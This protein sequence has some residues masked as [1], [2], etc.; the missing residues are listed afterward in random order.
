M[1]KTSETIVFFGSGP[2]AAK[3]L[4]L[5]NS[6][7]E[8]E[9][10]VTKPQPTHHR[11]VFPVIEIARKHNLRIMTASN[12]HELDELV[13]G[14]SFASRAAVLIDYG[15][16]VSQQTIDAF[17]LGILNSHFSLL[18]EWR[19][20]DPITFAILSGQDKTGVSLMM[21][22]TGLDEGPLIGV[23]EQTLSPTITAPELTN[24]LIDLSNALLKHDLPR[25]LTGDARGVPQEKMSTLIEKYP[26]RPSY[27]R[28]LTRDDGQLDWHKPA[29]QLEREVRAFL[30]WPKSHANVAN[31]DIIVTKAH[32]EPVSLAPGEI[33]ADQKQ[34]L[35]GC[36]SG[37]LSIDELKPPGKPAMST[38]AFLAGYGHRFK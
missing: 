15:I 11:E 5:L 8:I 3:S 18:P 24:K 2:V 20:A 28:K 4:E 25:F 31:L 10:V 6:W 29:E 13:A 17:E 26:D 21:L 37:S 9:A 27:S 12:R 36:S 1:R 32:V 38:A 35:I 33:K 7:C 19:G 16:I 22:T 34:L 14:A 23:G 30:E